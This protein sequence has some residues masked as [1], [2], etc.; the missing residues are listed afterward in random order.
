MNLDE[1][2]AK[3]TKRS[4]REQR[5]KNVGGHQRYTTGTFKLTTDQA[6]GGDHDD[7]RSGPGTVCNHVTA[8]KFD[9][10]ESH[11]NHAHW[12][13]VILTRKL[14]CQWYE[15]LWQHYQWGVSCSLCVR[16]V[17]P[18]PPLPLALTRTAAQSRNWHRDG[19]RTECQW[20]RSFAQHSK[21]P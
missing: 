3:C 8:W 20:T 12:T 11:P 10:T 4:K 7:V 17:P 9:N 5:K 2:K 1:S 19:D 16:G 14:D 18:L 15:Y 6:W 13:S 21:P